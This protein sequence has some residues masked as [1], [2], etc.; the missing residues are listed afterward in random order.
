[1]ARVRRE[2]VKIRKYQNFVVRL[3]WLVIILLFLAAVCVEYFLI[4]KPRLEQTYNGGP[5]DVESRQ[6]ILEEQRIYYEALKALEK[7]ANEINQAELEKVN[8]VIAE[9]MN[10]PDIL[11]QIF[12]LNK[13]EGMEPLGFDFAFD[14]GVLQINLH[15]KTSNYQDIK[16]YLDEIE[17]NIRIMDITSISIKGIGTDLSLTVQSYYLE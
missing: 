10:I 12:L 8:Y 1:M 14:Q 4:I 11:N 9:K 7:E 13:Q 6:V 17:K 15:L 16:K 2:Q 3:Y 5:L